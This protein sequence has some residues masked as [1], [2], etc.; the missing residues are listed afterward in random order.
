MFI[1]PAHEHNLNMPCQA[2]N[3][4]WDVCFNYN[5]HIFH[6]NCFQSMDSL[7]SIFMVSKNDFLYVSLLNLIQ[8]SQQLY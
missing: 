3:Q 4:N 6:L 7:F 1:V 2:I 8:Q 5:T